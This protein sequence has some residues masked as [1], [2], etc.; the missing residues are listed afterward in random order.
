MIVVDTNILCREVQH[1][2]IDTITVNILD[3]P[4]VRDRYTPDLVGLALQHQAQAA[5]QHAVD[6]VG[7]VRVVAESRAGRV[8]VAGDPVAHIL[9]LAA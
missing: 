1:Q 9:E 7:V 8:D 2:V 4:T 3:I 6:L 5:G